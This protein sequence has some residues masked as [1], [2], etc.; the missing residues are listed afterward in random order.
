LKAAVRNDAAA[1]KQ[2]VRAQYD[3]ENTW[4]DVTKFTGQ[5]KVGQELVGEIRTRINAGEDQIV[6]QDLDELTK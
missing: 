6:N 3:D 1:I 2:V 4:G 5:G